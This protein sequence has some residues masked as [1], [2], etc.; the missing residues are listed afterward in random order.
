MTDS[1]PTLAHVRRHRLPWRAAE[2][3]K[4]E[5]GQKPAE[6]ARVITWDELRDLVTRLGKQRASM[7]VCMTCWGRAHSWNDEE[8]YLAWEEN[9]EA[10][11]YRE[12]KPY[13]REETL[14]R[15]EL[16]AIAALVDAHR[17]EFAELI[18]GLEQMVS[19]EDLAA[20]RAEKRYR[21]IAHKSRRDV[22]DE[23][24]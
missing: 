14:M 24:R 17:D 9:P 4:T 6:F 8:F 1:E 12:L 21:R 16:R 20:R 22:R 18:Q 7:Q 23:L 5:C 13:G 2:L 11:L 19:P 10:L 3:T 15:R